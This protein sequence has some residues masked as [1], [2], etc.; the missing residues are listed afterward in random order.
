MAGQR[1]AIVVPGHGDIDFDGA[2]RITQR[3]L[4]LVREAERLVSL[5]GADAVVFS[6]WA[7]TGGPSEAEQMR[8]AWAG[9]RGELVVEPT[10][11][12]TPENAAPALPPPRGPGLAP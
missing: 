6:G 4:R 5:G 1:T 7:S 8:G 10:A 12:N 9:P 11:P 2:H 3:C